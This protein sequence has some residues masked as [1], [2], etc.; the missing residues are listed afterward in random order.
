MFQP[1]SLKHW[2]SL[3]TLFFISSLPP[4]SSQD[5]PKVGFPSPK[6]LRTLFYQIFLIGFIPLPATK[7]A[8]TSLFLHPPHSGTGLRRKK[9]LLCE[10]CLPSAIMQTPHLPLGCTACRSRG[11]PGRSLR[12]QRG[13]DEPALQPGC[14]VLL[15][16]LRNLRIRANLKRPSRGLYSHSAR[17]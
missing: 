15:L 1:Y 3:L 16:L 4:A 14:R 13:P 17:L 6:S 8:D 9:A 5:I 11:C 7:R 2:T 10:V 12:A